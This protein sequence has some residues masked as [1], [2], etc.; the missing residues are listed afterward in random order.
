MSSSSSSSGVDENLVRRFRDFLET[1]EFGYDQHVRTMLERKQKRLTIDINHLRDFDAPLARR[2][3]KE[4]LALLPAFQAGLKLFASTISDVSEKE[5][6]NVKYTIGVEGNFGANHVSPRQLEA[7]QLGSL[8]LVEGIVTKCSLVRPKVVK[9]AH[10]C[11]TTN[12]MHYRQYH[13]FTDLEGKA[14]SVTVYPTKDENDNPL[15]TEFG[16]SVYRDHQTISLQEMPERSPAGQ[17]PR[18]VDVILDNDLVDLAK[19]GDRVQ[20]IGIYRAVPGKSGGSTRGVFRT[21]LI[22]NN[23]VQLGKEVQ[24]PKITGTDIKNIRELGDSPEVFTKLA[25]SLAPSIYGHDHIKKAL[26]LM[27]MGGVEQ[28]LDNGTHLRG[29]INVLLVGDPSCGKSQLLR[30]VLHLAPLAISTSGRGSSGVGLTAAVSNDSETG[31]RRLE[32]GAMVLAD[33]GVVTIDEFDKMSEDDR[34]AIHEV[35]EQQTVTINKAGIHA[36]LN[37]RCSVLAA[38]NPVYGQYNRDRKP[39]ENIGL[40]DSLLS[41]FDMLFIV[42]D[43]LNPTHDRSISDHVLRMHRYRPAGDD[44]SDNWDAVGAVGNTNNT[45]HHMVAE[46]LKQREDDEDDTAP[47]V[48]KFNQLLHGGA[49]AR[50]DV[51]SIAFIKKYIMYAKRFVKPKLNEE[52]SQVIAQAYAELR[53]MEDMKTLPITP[54]TL[55]TMIRLS[56]AHARIRLSNRIV[57]EDVTAALQLMKY[58]LYHEA[59]PN[60]RESNIHSSPAA[61]KRRRHEKNENDASQAN[62][63]GGNKKRRQDDGVKEAE[64]AADDAA[65][66][67]DQSTVELTAARAADFSKRLFAHFESL[68]AQET[69]LE[70]LAQSVNRGNSLPFSKADIDTLLIQLEDKDKVMC[71]D[72]LVLLM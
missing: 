13:D 12:E 26:L 53:S 7:S 70:D 51:Y 56:A 29:D 72:D 69:T 46:A 28:N 57:K 24:G 43:N 1:N 63:D 41:R 39:T 40:P 37:A 64:S 32:A 8:V 44:G 31:E 33:R 36:T 65:A 5:T 4:P 58:A 34:V 6:A 55:E 21:V 59:D 19:P 15:E 50:E 11:P 35:M 62:D 10:F 27:L 67:G 68:H 71:T 2:F 17:L 25:R 18:S 3:L 66:S 30:F 42:L 9:S 49:A 22:A 14:P 60:E 20:L 52:A 61:G 47:M 23:L 54:R 38:A 45:G 16:L 48:Q